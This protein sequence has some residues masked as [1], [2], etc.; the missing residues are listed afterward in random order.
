MRYWP[1]CFWDKPVESLLPGLALE[2]WQ[3]PRA[4]APGSC[5]DHAHVTN[6]SP[7]KHLLTTCNPS[8]A[9]PPRAAAG[10]ASLGTTATSKERLSATL[11][12]AGPYSVRQ[13]TAA[14]CRRIASH[15]PRILCRLPFRQAASPRPS[16]TSPA[17][18]LDGRGEGEP[19]CLGEEGPGQP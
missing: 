2:P 19:G 14:P 11:P 13:Q 10:Q 8:R 4:T 16:S 5:T 1:C 6:A 17:P 9:Q 18:A 12:Q 7:A 3:R 15:T